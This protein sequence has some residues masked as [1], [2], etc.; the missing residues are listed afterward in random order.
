MKKSVILLPW[1]LLTITLHAQPVSLGQNI[2][3]LQEEH[4]HGSTLVQLSNG[5]ILT[6]WFQGNGERWADD[7]RIMGARYLTKKNQWSAPFV[8]AD[9]PEFPDINPVLFLDA[10]QQLWLVWY[11]VIANQWE[12]SLLKYRTST[13]YL[14]DGPP[15]WSWQDVIHVKPGD[16]TERGMKEDDKFVKSVEEQFRAHAEDLLKKGSSPEQLE[17]WF[18]FKDDILSKARGE[19]MV[20]RGERYPY[21]RRM[22]WQ[23]KNKPFLMGERILL[24]LYSDGLEMSLFAIT[25]D[26]GQHWKSSTPLV[27]IA[28]I[29]AS[30]AKKKDGTLVAYMRDNGPPPQR[31]PMSYSQDNGMTWSKVEDSQLPNPGSGSD[32]VTLENGH[33]V[34][35]YNDTEKGRH[36]LA[37]SL[38]TDE[39][40]T[41]AFTRHLE[42]DESEKPATGA[43]PAIIA[44]KGGKIYVTYSYTKPKPEGGKL[45]N[46]R[47]MAIDEGWI[48]AGNA[49]K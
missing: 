7:V 34:I 1:L 3:P 38:S 31:H 27:G 2:F 19:D 20:R 29:Q 6:A 18:R 42:R 25:D 44:G 24:P 40:K 13:D 35:A 8:M 49:R 45:E 5:D 15:K 48:K 43:Y 26:Y 32:V 39:G 33:W 12:T 37:V 21:F 30:V 17:Q 47:F 36:S 46:I 9:V 4:A 11:T 22:G 14:Q 41:W 23:T 10:K 28:N 16:P